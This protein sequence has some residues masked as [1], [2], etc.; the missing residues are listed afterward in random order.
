MA[1]RLVKLARVDYTPAVLAVPPTPAYCT[2]RTERRAIS[3]GGSMTLTI[4]NS[5][6]NQVSQPSSVWVY[7]S[8]GSGTTSYQNVRTQVC[9]PAIP[10]TPGIP[11]QAQE[12]VEIGWDA[13]AHSIHAFS[14]DFRFEFDIGQDSSGVLCGLAPAGIPSA[15]YNTIRYGLR[16][17]GDQLTVVE[18]GRM[19]V[20]APTYT[21][22][23]RLVIQRLGG[24]VTYRVGDWTYESPL[25]S[26]NSLG[27]YA[28]LYVTGDFVDNPA[29]HRLFSFGVDTAWGWIDHDTESAV[30]VRA[31][32]GW[33]GEAS[34]GEGET[35][36]T[37][38][39]TVWANE[40]AVGEA[41][42]DVGGVTLAANDNIRLDITGI[43]HHI[44]MNMSSVGLSINSGEVD[45]DAGGA[46]VKASDYMH[47]EVVYEAATVEVY[48]VAYDEAPGTGLASELLAMADIYT[49]DPVLYAVLYEGLS[50]GEHLDVFLAIDASLIDYLVP[51]DR[52]DAAAILVALLRSSLHI[53]DDIHRAKAEMLQYATNLAT[54]AVGRYDGFGF[55]GFT[56]VGMHTYGWKRDGLYRIVDAEDSG[57]C[58][59]ALVDF[60]AED[61]DTTNRKSIRALFFGADTDGALYARLVDD[62]DRDT[63]YRVIPHGD[64]QRAN[65]AQRPTSRFWR[66]R[67][68]IVDATFADLD[69]VEWKAATTGRRTRS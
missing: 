67:L 60:A 12:T 6:P 11:A 19:V 44:P 53:S 57:E 27:V 47:G 69:N 34:I 48:A 65:P 45:W 25:R 16:Q 13:G 14:G 20:E 31:P 40:T 23:Q 55:S 49:V 21:P 62:N 35:Y 28:C 63:T 59:Q 1:N 7:E 2:T 17:V 3:S 46:L 9:Y 32:W 43:I 29:V 39:V 56:R 38:P 36:V 8:R 15:E 50:V 54:G 4:Y 61:F 37:V 64:T 42:L 10:G 24:V 51:S 5:G 33:S 52:Y 68:E 30:A 18:L 66:L 26:V 41:R 22:G 58:I